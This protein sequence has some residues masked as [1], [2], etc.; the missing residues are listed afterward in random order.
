MHP[1][2]RQISI[3]VPLDKLSICRICGELHG[4]LVRGERVG[5]EAAE[6]APRQLNQQCDCTSTG[7][8]APWDGY[9]FNQA[10][11]LCRCCGRRLL[12]SGMRWSEWFCGD[13]LPQIE[14]MNTRCRGTLIPSSRHTLMTA[15]ADREGETQPLPCLN[16]ELGDWFDRVELLEQHAR[17]VIHENLESLGLESLDSDVLLGVYL[18][19]LPPSQA[20]LKSSLRAL[21]EMFGMPA[22]LLHGIA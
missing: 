20:A 8:V 10:V 15:L 11:T 4:E 6:S 17:R 18:E 21:A 12:I 1:Q 16:K 9:D 7:A 19:Q 13:C 14:K 22:H 2:A 3:H 5:N